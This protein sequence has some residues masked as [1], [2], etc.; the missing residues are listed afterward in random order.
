MGSAIAT[1]FEMPL[2][3]SAIAIL[4]GNCTACLITTLIATGV[5]AIV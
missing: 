5:I 1:L 3:K 2:L 4:L